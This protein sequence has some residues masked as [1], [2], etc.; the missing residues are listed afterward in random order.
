[1]LYLPFFVRSRILWSIEE[2]EAIKGSPVNIPE[3]LAVFSINYTTKLTQG[4]MWAFLYNL[5]RED[6]FYA[7]KKHT[8]WSMS[9]EGEGKEGF[10]TFSE[11]FRRLY[12]GYVLDKNMR[13]RAGSATKTINLK[14]LCNLLKSKDEALW[15]EHAW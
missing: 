8:C 7:D 15:Y 14:Q 6:L 13:I 2:G 1:M 4:Y 10:E 5:Y 3:I 9:N 12:P 11:R